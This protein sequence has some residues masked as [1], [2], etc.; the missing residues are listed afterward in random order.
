MAVD[1]EVEVD[2]K[3]IRMVKDFHGVL[4][5]YAYVEFVAAAANGEGSPRSRP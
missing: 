4:K 3:E 2:I 1:G 5:G